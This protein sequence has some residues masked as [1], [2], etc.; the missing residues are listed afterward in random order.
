MLV[1]N[2][3]I[4]WEYGTSVDANKSMLCIA[5]DHTTGKELSH[6]HAECS[7]GD[8]FV[9]ETGRR[10]SLQRLLVVLSA[11]TY[12]FSMKDRKDFRARVWEKYRT[13]TKQPRWIP[14]TKVTV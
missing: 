4:Y 8:T 9:K 11:I 1:D 6:G 13:L 3:R 2:I 7:V 5:V 10:I 12:P 14:R